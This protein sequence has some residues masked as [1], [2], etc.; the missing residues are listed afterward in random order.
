MLPADHD[1]ALKKQKFTMED[2]DSD[3]QRKIK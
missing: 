2:N 1:S 3:I